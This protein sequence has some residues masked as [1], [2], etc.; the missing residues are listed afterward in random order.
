MRTV[1]VAIAMAALVGAGACS[2]RNRV[3]VFDSHDGSIGGGGGGGGDDGGGGGGGPPD[4]A[5]VCDPSEPPTCDG[6]GAVKTCRADGTGWD[7]LLCDDSSTCMHGVCVCVVGTLACAGN[8]VTRCM[9]NGTFQPDHACASGA[10]CAGGS[11]LDARCPNEIMSTNPH[12]LPVDG[13]PRFRHDN[14]NTGLSPARLA[15]T[16][17]LRWKKFIG[18]TAGQSDSAF[19][20]SDALA[21]GPVVNQL[22]IIFIGAGELDNLGGALHAVDHGGADVYTFPAMRGYGLSTP[23]VRQDGTA[24]FSTTNSQLVAVSPTGTQQWAYTTGAQAD[25]DPIITKDGTL[26][27]SSDDD[28]VYAVT[29]TGTLIWQ[30]DPASGPGEVD[31]GLAESCDGRLYAAGKNGWFAIDE[32][33]GATL[34]SVPATGNRGGVPIGA[35]L[36]SP[37]VTADGRM[38][39]FDAA[40]LGVGIDPTGHVLWT[41][42]LVARRARRAPRRR[43]RPA[44]STWC[45]TTARST[46]SMRRPAPSAGTAPSATACPARAACPRP[47]ST[48]T[49][50][51]S[52]T[53]RAASTSTR[54]TATSTPSTPPARRSGACPRAARPRTSTGPARWRS[55]R[56]APCTSPATT[57]ICTRSARGNAVQIAASPRRAERVT[58]R[59]AARADSSARWRRGVRP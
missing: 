59:S 2:G 44:C 38:F 33:T 58:A 36:S 18:G 32:K 15:A 45:S 9:P 8:T 22:D 42:Q 51:R 5:R 16:P 37:L 41:Q 27:Y 25:S 39:G 23:A 50:A 7:D 21:S 56:T 40:G 49:P 48:S 29:A 34:W 24:Y 17:Q 4:L 19:W 10:T 6:T 14:R 31:G 26:I 35:L 11:C 28:S 46:R 55:A 20:N 13:W 47:R 12:A 3:I 57:A 52:S 54:T 53:G 43:C 1:A 30:S